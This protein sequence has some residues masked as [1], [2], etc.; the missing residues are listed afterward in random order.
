MH[1]NQPNLYGLIVQMYVQPSSGK[2][3]HEIFGDIESSRP[4]HEKLYS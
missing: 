4:E 3:F 2:T 1:D